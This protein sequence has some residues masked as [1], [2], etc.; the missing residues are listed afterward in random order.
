MMD[1][2]LDM[3]FSKAIE[4]NFEAIP[5]SIVQIYALILAL[6]KSMGAL[7]SILVS[8]ATIAF[9]SSII[10]FD[11]DKSPSQRSKSPLFYGFVP[12]KALAPRRL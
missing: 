7:I 4:T 3:T 2:L 1:P 5:A 12:D 9:T 8:A 11:W 10:S 6:K